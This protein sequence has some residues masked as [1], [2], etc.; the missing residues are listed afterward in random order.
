MGLMDAIRRAEER[1]RKVT[2]HGLELARQEWDDV[3]RRLRHRMRMNPRE[4]AA[5]DGHKRKPIVSIN[6]HDVSDE[7]F[8]DIRR[9]A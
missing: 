2:R 8:D 3:E 4:P 5:G 9:S 1:S 7:Q 6:G